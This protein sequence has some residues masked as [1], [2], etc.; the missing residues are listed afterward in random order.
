METRKI[1]HKLFSGIG[2][3]LALF[4]GNRLLEWLA[5]HFGALRRRFA[6]VNFNSRSNGELRVIQA[7]EVIDPQV[8][9]D[10]GANRGDWSA[11]VSERYPRCHIHAFEILPATFAQLRSR[12]AGW[13]QMT[14]NNIGLAAAPGTVRMHTST[15][16]DLTS[17]AYPLEG[18][19]EHAA[20][21]TGSEVCPVTTGERYVQEQ[22]IERI[23]MLKIDVEGMD[24]Q[25]IKG[26]GDGLQQIRVIQFEYGIFNIASR[27][28]L[29]DF[30]TLLTS[31]GFRV[32][33]I[34][35][36]T[37]EFF[38]YH[39]LRED[40]LGNNYLAVR[41]KEEALLARLQR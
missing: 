28:L 16:D 32:V 34:Y 40:F 7:L 6:N 5:V 37:V 20:H 39:Y 1:L 22:G 29:Y 33:K 18:L 23:D 17:T 27:D 21:Y 3:L 15:D 41:R 38:D 35:P 25:V 31:A 9:L 19:A 8:V 4:R 10:V 30:H 2:H 26:F 11:L 12:T 24:L 13:P 36:R 14:I